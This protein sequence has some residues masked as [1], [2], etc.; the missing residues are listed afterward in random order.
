MVGIRWVQLLSSTITGGDSAARTHPASI[1]TGRRN[2]TMKIPRTPL[3]NSIQ[4][5]MPW[6]DMEK[7]CREGRLVEMD[8]KQR[9]K[10][11][12]LYLFGAIAVFAVALFAYHVFG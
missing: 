4:R 9:R 12:W 11:D 6:A 2:R 5:L 1:N 3:C 10:G 7:A 8:R